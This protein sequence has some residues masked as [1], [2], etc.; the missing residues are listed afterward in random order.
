[1]KRHQT[2]ALLLFSIGLT[3]STLVF[4]LVGC[5]FGCDHTYDDGEI[6]QQV[7]CNEEGETT[8]TCTQCGKTITEKIS[9]KSKFI[10]VYYAYCKTPWAEYGSDFSYISI[11][12]YPPY[13]YSQYTYMSEATSAIRKINADLGIPEYVYQD[14]TKTTALQGRQTVTFKLVTVTWTYHPDN[15]LEVTYRAN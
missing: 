10:D 1:M 13:A 3:I 4:L 12:T 7:T 2:K 11:D 6:T 9:I 15:G 14:M 5:G 8:Y